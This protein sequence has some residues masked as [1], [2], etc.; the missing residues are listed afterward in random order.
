MITGKKMVTCH[1]SLIRCFR[2]LT[3]DD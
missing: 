1:W 2:Q 3:N